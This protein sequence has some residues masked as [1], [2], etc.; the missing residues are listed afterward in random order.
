MPRLC[1]ALRDLG[2]D[3]RIVT[4]R[5]GDTPEDPFIAAH[6]HDFAGIPL[7]RVL[8]LSSCLAREARSLARASD[9]VHA[10]GLWLMPNVQAGRAAAAAGRP[11]IVSPRGMLAPE[12]LAF[13]SARKRLFWRLLQTCLCAR[14]GLARDQPG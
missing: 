3:A 7:L 14:S 1:R 5:E 2:A 12:A 10:H 9:I 11:L 13:S 4:V 8:R 6:A